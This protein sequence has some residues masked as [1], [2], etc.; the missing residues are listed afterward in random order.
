MKKI[1]SQLLQRNTPNMG[2]EG[3]LQG[4]LQTTA[5]RNQR[6]Q[7]QMEKHSMLIARKS[8]YRENGHIVQ[9]NL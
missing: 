6:R 5:P 8:E 9:S 4:E 2:S 7:K 1:H 3:L